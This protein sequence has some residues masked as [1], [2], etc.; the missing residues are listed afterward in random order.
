MRHRSSSG[1]DG[2]MMAAP[3]A[4]PGVFGLL[5]FLV[6]VALVG[7][8][9]LAANGILREPPPAVP[10]PTPAPSG[11]PAPA[12]TGAAVSAIGASFA[13][14][15]R[16]LLV[17]LV[18]CLAGSVVASLGIKLFFSARSAE[19]N[20]RQNAATA[21]APPAPAAPSAN[22]RAQTAPPAPA[23]SAPRAEESPTLTPKGPPPPNA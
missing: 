13:D 21:D 23:P 5:I 17:L 20:A 2:V 16:R 14:L 3:S 11:S 8:V 1:P 9:F 18:M 15:V 22:G 7:Y 4:L 6:G 19:G 12:A 10:T